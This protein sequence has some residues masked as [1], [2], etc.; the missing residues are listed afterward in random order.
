MHRGHIGD[1]MI[2]Q[3]ALRIAQTSEQPRSDQRRQRW[4]LV[5]IAVGAVVVLAVALLVWRTAGRLPAD[6]SLEAGFARDMMI[7]HDQAVAMALLIR[8]RTADPAVKTLATDILLTQENQ[9][10][11]MLGWLN[12]WGLPATSAEPPMAWMGHPVS[13][14]MPGMA[15]PEELAHLEHLSGNAADTEFLR[16]MI[17]HHQGGIPMAEEAIA[18]SGNDQVRA[19]ATAIVAAQQSEI[20]AMEDLLRQ[21]ETVPAGS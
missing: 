10:G 9:I 8:D 7:H 21:K 18:R 12:V 2:D 11:Q 15:T 5:A 19:L 13:G 20:T 4:L 14:R 6:D 17:R 16:L 1:R 3:A